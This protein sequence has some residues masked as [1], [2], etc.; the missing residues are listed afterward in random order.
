MSI[1][2]TPFPALNPPDTRSTCH[3]VFDP[4]DGVDY[5]RQLGRAIKATGRKVAPLSPDHLFARPQGRQFD[6]LVFVG[7]E[8]A[9]ISPAAAAQRVKLAHSTGIKS[10]GVVARSAFSLRQ[11]PPE[12]DDLFVYLDE[13]DE[14]LHRGAPSVSLVDRL[15]GA[16][17][18]FDVANRSGV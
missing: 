4:Q 5:A 10:V 13:E 16:L 2:M 8:A 7:T 11:I 18:G 17:H 14:A 9:M 12:L 15:E 3:I 1:M 6:V